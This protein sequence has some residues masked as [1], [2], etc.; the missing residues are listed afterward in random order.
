VDHELP[1]PITTLNPR[2]RFWP[3]C[4]IYFRRFR[5][6]LW[7]VLLALLSAL[8]YLNQV[9][10][11]GFVKQPLLDKLRARGLELE[12]SRLRLSWY[13]GIVAE[14]VRFGRAD[15]PLGPRVTFAQVQV[16]LNYRA[17]AR[18][19][20]QVDA[21]ALHHGRLVWPVAQTNQAPRQLAVE[22]IQTD[23][24][25]LPNDEWALDNFRAGFVGARIQLS[26]TLTHASAA[27]DWKFFQPQP[28]ARAAGRWQ[29][30]LQRLADALER[31]DFGAPPD[32]RL[33]LRGDARDFQSFSVR[34]SASAPA[35]QTPWG[36]LA[37]GRFSARLLPATNSELSRAELSL[38]AANAQTPW[39]NITN[40]LLLLH[41]TSAEGQT[42]RFNGDLTLKAS[43]A[44]T[45]WA[46]ATN[47][48][49]KADFASVKDETNLVSS[50][51]V[52]LVERATSKWGSGANARLTAQCLLALTNPVPLSGQ[53]RLD[54]GPLETQWGRARQVQLLARLFTNRQVV[55]QPSRLSP[56]PLALDAN[57]GQTPAPLPLPPKEGGPTAP[58]SPL[59]DHADWAGW[60][61]LEPYALDWECRLA[62]LEARQVAGKEITCRGAWR[63]P[64]L[65]LTNLHATFEHGQIDLRAALNVATRLLEAAVASDADPRQLAP[66]LPESARRWL[67][68]FTWEQPPSLSA[69][70]GLVLPAWTNRPPDWRRQLQPTLRLEG[71]FNAPQGGACR[72]VPLSSAQSHFSYSNLCWRLPDLLLTRPEGQLRATCQL[73]ERTRQFYGHLASSVDVRVAR[74]LLGPNEQR[75]LDDFS[76]AQPP[77]I[78]AEVW[79][80]LQGPA[81]LGIRGRVALTNFSFRGESASGFQ[82]GLRYTNLVLQLLAPRL[83]RGHQQLNADGLTADFQA[84]KI[85]LTN[86][87]S[88]TEP[89]VV[90]RAIGPPTARSLEPFRFLQPPTVHAQGVIPMD[91]E[92]DADLYFQVEGGPFRWLN[93]RLPQVA[94]DIHWAGLRL[95]LSDVRMDFYGGQASGSA[96]FYFDPHH[97]GTDCQFTLITTNTLLQSLMADL[98]TRTNHLEGRLSGS[99]ALA[100]AN[101]EDWRQTEGYGALEL[102]DG[103][104]W[105]IPLFGILSPALNA[106]APGL[107]SSRANA[108]TCSFVI[109]NG[110]IRSDDLDIRSH[111]MRLQYRGTADLQGRLNVRVEAM[112]LRDMPLFGPLV[113]TVFWPVTKLF[114][115]KVTGSLNQPKAEPLY[116]LPRI[117]LMPLHPWRTLKGLRPEEPPLTRTNAPPAATP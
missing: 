92:A 46:T 44:Q 39:A 33:D 88:T 20:F 110:V 47:V 101:S 71:E 4:R 5:I 32:L 41:L 102:R 78:E 113:S 37:Q 95:T 36:T 18:R 84:R 107:G 35:A 68:Q 77:V 66:L 81:E 10:L 40:F 67:A 58:T 90:A 94:G 55:E 82:T 75:G 79:G 2:S 61:R 103:L 83:Q 3:R 17:L 15:H 21:L 73:D 28:Q 98:A 8:V 25:F 56:A 7:L 85:Y 29:A 14:N 69:H 24:R 52:L 1:A 100:K 60:A 108:G 16:Q 13:L 64:S 27:R 48:Q 104:I 51:L 76:F 86:G 30:R 49:L 53:A 115:Y 97:P 23:L 26:G 109:T 31:I 11:P 65:T 63:A 62:E 99:L 38:G 42:N 54:C 114:E 57:A 87:F 59:S 111:A 9:G 105:D 112:L 91:G 80:Q 96:S 43:D 70:A 89:M 6:A 72:A 12:F 45:R 19:Q 106:L 117:V 50:D 74:P 22:N 34:L 116:L 93:F